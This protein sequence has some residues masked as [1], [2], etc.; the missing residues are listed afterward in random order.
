[1][2]KKR[3]MALVAVVLLV[4]VAAQA[5][6]YGR[7]RLSPVDPQVAQQQMQNPQASGPRPRPDLACKRLRLP[8]DGNIYLVNPEGN[9][10]WI[11]NTYT[12]NLLFRDWT[13][14]YDDPDLNE[15]ARTADLENGSA[16]IR[17]GGEDKVYFVTNGTKRWIT[18]PEVMDRCNFRWPGQDTSLPP[19]VV[20]AIP[21]GNN[22]TA[23]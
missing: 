4:A 17:A 12:F 5:Q 16:V 13:G 8:G 6:S 11:P 20:D 9:R 3:L 23:K 10:Q 18:S 1:M 14:I 19:A 15:I 22:W 7:H 21:T 2:A